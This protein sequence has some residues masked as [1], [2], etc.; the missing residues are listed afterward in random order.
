MVEN[1]I[2][3][4]YHTL[5]QLRN[6]HENDVYW[7]DIFSTSSLGDSFQNGRGQISTEA[8]IVAN[9]LY[10]RCQHRVAIPSSKNSIY[11]HISSDG[12]DNP[13]MPII[14][15][16]LSHRNTASCE[17][18]KGLRQCRSCTTEF[19]IQISQFGATGHILETTYWKNFGAG[20]SAG[21]P[22]W[23]QHL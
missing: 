16:L 6:P 7:L 17:K 2:F 19:K 4:P 13:L 12:P 9:E 10:M 14:K 18:C 1:Q 22:K 3:L 8:C 23:V 20:R 11:P 5:R 21:D 15:C